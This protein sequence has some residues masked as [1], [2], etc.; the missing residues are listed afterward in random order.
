MKWKE[1]DF[2]HKLSGNDSYLCNLLSS[3]QKND[4]I[5]YPPAHLCCSVEPHIYQNI[6]ILN[7]QIQLEVAPLHTAMS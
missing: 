7:R 1:F 5:F 4:I 6:K 2:D 3:G